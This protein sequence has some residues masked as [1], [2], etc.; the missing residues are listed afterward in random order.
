M[1][2]SCNVIACDE[3]GKQLDAP[4]LANTHGKDLEIEHGRSVVSH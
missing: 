3:N 2:L 1:L 4:Y